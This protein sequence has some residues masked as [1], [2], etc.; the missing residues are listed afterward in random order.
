M[1]NFKI[2]QDVPDSARVKIY[3]SDGSSDLVLRTDSTGALEVVSA[4]ATTDLSYSWTDITSEDGQPDTDHEYSV[5]NYNEWS[6]GLTSPITTSGD[7]WVQLQI[8][9][10]GD[11]WI[12]NGA[13]VTLSGYS[14]GVLV[15][16][17][18]LKYARIYYGAVNSTATVGTLTVYFQAQA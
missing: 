13:R 6:L 15:A 5:L 7:V 1:P 9:P 10:D 4:L 18:F 11:F 2:I 3:G 16:D 12:D 8:S 17:K 14:A